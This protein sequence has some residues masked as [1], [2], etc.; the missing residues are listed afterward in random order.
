M[1]KYLLTLITAFVAVVAFAQIAPIRQLGKTDM[2]QN[3][4]VEKRLTK[5]ASL[6]KISAPVR[7]KV[8]GQKV[9]RRAALTSIDEL[10]GDFIIANEEYDLDE[11][12]QY[13]VPAEV[14]HAGNAATIEVTGEN[15]IAIYGF[16]PEATSADAPITATVDLAKSTIT[17]PVGQ[18][19]FTHA[20]YGA[21]TLANASGEGDLTGTIY[22]GGIIAL[23]DFWIDELVYQGTN[24][25][26]SNFYHYTTVAPT[27][28]VMEY[29]ARTT[30]NGEYAPQTLNV[31]ITQDED[32]KAVTVYN[33]SI[34]GLAADFDLFTDKTFTLSSDNAVLY[35]GSTYGMYYIIGSTA[36]GELSFDV[37]GKVTETTLTSDDYWTLYSYEGYWRYAQSPFTITRTD[38]V[39]FEVPA[40]EIGELVNPPAGLVTK[41]YP[42][43]AT[44]WYNAAQQKQGAYSSTAKIG[45][46]GNDVYFQG[47]DKDIPEAWVKGAYDAEAKTVTIP[48]TYT[49]IFEENVHYFAAYGG[50]PKDLVLK[51]SSDDDTFDYGATVMIYKG[52]NTTSF[53]YF[54]NGF[55]IGVK[56]S[57]T[58][59]PAGL[60][61]TDV[62]YKGMYRADGD[63]EAAE[64]TGTVKV[65]WDGNDVYIQNLIPV[66]DGGWIKGTRN[67][68]V[69]TFAQNQ[70]IGNL[71][72]GLSC[73]LT[74]FVSGA[75]ATSDVTFTYD[76]SKAT[77]TSTSM[78]IATRFKS[79]TSYEAYY[80]TGLVI[81]DID[82]GINNI[83][84]NTNAENAPTYNLKGQRVNSGYKGLVIKNGKKFVVK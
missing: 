8:L 21:I 18:T 51:Y 14:A 10:N 82:T 60:T 9:S 79:S 1:K 12:N 35:G 15:T 62:K 24:Y 39:E 64:V 50:T 22:E 38:G 76:E 84:A 56:P 43:T 63:S 30:N 7:T 29:E 65:G 3:G 66:V 5:R 46:D 36:A 54:Y 52:S 72:N 78:L 70:Y 37:P 49:G 75:E 45:W 61:T 67:G 44:S 28:G 32:T 19:L 13:Y 26:W 23:D 41:E 83:K 68:D 25:V 69:V 53:A 81:G 80:Q 11:T 47:L 31:L 6:K 58:T 16:S 27:N 77:F 42:V 2:L 34:W 33:F 71:S 20:T 55:F 17:I 48:V 40:L 4:N 57:P 73:Y 74:G 59:P